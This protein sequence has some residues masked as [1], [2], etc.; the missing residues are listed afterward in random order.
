ME[1]LFI[2]LATVALVIVYRG[3]LKELADWFSGR[4]RSSYLEKTR[5]KLS[6]FE[7]YAATF[8]SEFPEQVLAGLLDIVKSVKGQDYVTDPSALNG[9]Q[10]EIFCF[11]GDSLFRFLADIFGDES[12]MVFI[13]EIRNRALYKYLLHNQRD[14]EAVTAI[15]S[16]RSNQLRRFKTAAGTQ[17]GSSMIHHF[18]Q[19]M[20]ELITGNKK[21]ALS[22]SLQSFF[23]DLYKRDITGM[24]Q[25]SFPNLQFK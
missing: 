25:A 14:A 21:D 6:G 5:K 18:S 24:L 2:I 8:W 15:V 16:E 1:T 22:V 11:I 20:S 7:G 17:D 19:H 13:D 12:A 4:S 9:I 10:D 23:T 3:R